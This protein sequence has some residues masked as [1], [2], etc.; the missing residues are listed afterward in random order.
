MAPVFASS[1]SFMAPQALSYG[2]SSSSYM[3]PA[4][5]Q[6]IQSYG[7]SS[8]S[9][10]PLT[11]LFENDLSSVLANRDAGMNAPN[12]VAPEM[13]QLGGG[14]GGGGDAGAAAGAAGAG[15]EAAQ[16]GSQ[17]PLLQAP[18]A[19]M[20]IFRQRSLAPAAQPT[21]SGLVSNDINKFFDV[22]KQFAGLS[23]FSSPPAPAPKPAPK[24]P[25]AKP[26]VTVQR[27]CS[28]KPGCYIDEDGDEICRTTG[29]LSK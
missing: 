19:A 26:V 20:Q 25:A 2:S 7:S 29:L 6:E 12:P 9:Y 22:A 24:P 18:T 3:A 21:L 14:G 16:A 1:S 8:S 4:P 13:S 23:I 15:G 28:R 17:Q 10:A 27:G 5:L 11:G